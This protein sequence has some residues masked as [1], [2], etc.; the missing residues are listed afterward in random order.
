MRARGWKCSGCPVAT[1]SCCCRSPTAAPA[2]SMSSSRSGWVT[3][4]SSWA[5]AAALPDLRD[6]SVSHDHPARL[7]APGP[8]RPRGDAGLR[9][10]ADLAGARPLLQ[11]RRSAR[12]R[13][14][15]RRL[16]ARLP[17]RQVS[18]WT[19]VHTTGR[20]GARAPLG[21]RPLGASPAAAGRAGADLGCGTGRD[22]LWFARK[23]RPVRAV[24]FA[25][26]AR[27]G[28]CA[29]RAAVAWTSTF[30]LV[31]L[32]DL[33]AVLSLAP[34]SPALPTTCTRA[35]SSAASTTRSAPTCGGCAG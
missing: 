7:R 5:T 10:R 27:S 17:H 20:R 19:D 22:A 14:P 31:T 1:S 16:A 3:P 2:T 32:N 28:S 18:A 25:R 12:R 13:T 35:T 34:S 30:D 9:L 6:P 24:D 23:G 15:P 29:G 8:G 26:A 4:S 11:V 21:L 33:R